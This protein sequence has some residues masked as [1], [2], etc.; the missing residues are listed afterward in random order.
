MSEPVWALDGGPVRS[1][2]FAPMERSRIKV[3]SCDN[4]A[5]VRRAIALYVENA[6]SLEL[7]ASLAT[8]EEAVEYVATHPVEVLLLDIRMPGLDGF[9][10]VD[11]ITQMGRGTRIIF[12][13][14]FLDPRVT[15]EV[16]TG[17]VA[18]LLGKGVEPAT[19]VKAIHVARDG[20]SVLDPAGLHAQTDAAVT[21]VQHSPLAANEREAEVLRLLFLGQSNADI[22]RTMHLSESSV[23]AVLATLMARANVTNR[24]ALVLAAIEHQSAS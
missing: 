23:K 16:M 1:G 12:L 24:T 10:V 18:G 13:T 17:R 14:S 15:R 6:P 5:F 8:G 7:V 3:A 21:H 19:L 20:L 4:D 22:A 11:R 2:S 9:G